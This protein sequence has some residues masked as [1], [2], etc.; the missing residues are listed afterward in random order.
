[1]V[2][3]ITLTND[4]LKTISDLGRT[5]QVMQKS[6]SELEEK[7]L[8]YQKQIRLMQDNIEEM[9]SQISE[10]IKEL[11][12]Q[13]AN[14]KFTMSQSLGTTHREKQHYYSS[15]S[16]AHPL[17]K[18]SDEVHNIGSRIVK[19]EQEVMILKPNIDEV[20]QTTYGF[21]SQLVGSVETVQNIRETIS[22]HAVAM[23]EVK[24]RQDILDVK[25]VNGAFIWKIPEVERRHREAQD[26][27]TLSLY[28]PPFHT[29]PHGYRM[30]IRTY[31]NGD[32]SGKGFYISVFFVLMKSEHDDLLA[33]PF[34]R[35]VTFE[36]VNQDNR[37]K[38]ILETFMP[39]VVSPSFQKPTSEMNV[40]SGFPKFAQ[41]S[42]L[43]DPTFTKGDSIFIRCK[44]DTSGLQLE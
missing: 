7:S 20:R 33:W 15:S 2:D 34:R 17:G 11:Q 5:R 12:N 42:V 8:N 37:A 10:S 24:L 38:G 32:G 27:R 29:S 26:R 9:A 21:N 4:S 23:D 31:L 19:L 39:D 25:T 28:S 1:M 40:A 44:I 35:P 30:C 43:K 13:L 14:T 41:Q 6:L 36:L 18:V 16:E 22:R 3:L